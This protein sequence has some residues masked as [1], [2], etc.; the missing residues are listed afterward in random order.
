MRAHISSNNPRGV[1]GSTVLELRDV[2]II[3]VR[4][5]GAPECSRRPMPSSEFLTLM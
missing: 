5:G 2:V 4:P 3:E 1:K